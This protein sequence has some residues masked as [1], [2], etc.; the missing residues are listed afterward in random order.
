MRRELIA[1]GCR[2]LNVGLVL[3]LHYTSMTPVRS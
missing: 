1:N 2:S 3:A